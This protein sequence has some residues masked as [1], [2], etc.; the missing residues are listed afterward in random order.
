VTDDNA[1][2]NIVHK[3]KDVFNILDSSK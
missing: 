1:L 2:F 3:I